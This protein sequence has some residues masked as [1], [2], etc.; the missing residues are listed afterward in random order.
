MK[1]FQDQVLKE[2]KILNDKQEK[3]AK[4][5]DEMAVKVV[6][7]KYVETDFEEEDWS[8]ENVNIYFTEDI[9]EVDEMVV[10]CG[11]P[12]TL[13]G[14]KHLKEYLKRHGL[15]DYDLEKVSCKQRFKFG[16]SQVY[17]STEKAKILIAMKV[18]NA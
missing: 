11:A 7:S 10:D 6:N 2:L 12:K 16:P 1:E 5:Q 9:E 18:K 13:I 8:K 17:I 14:E 15:V 4:I 3:M